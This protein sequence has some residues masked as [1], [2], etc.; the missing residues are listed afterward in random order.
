MAELTAMCEAERFAGV[1]TYIASR[2]VVFVSDRGAASIKATLDARLTV[3]GDK[4]VGVR[5]RA[6]SEMAAVL[7][8]SPFLDS[9]PNR[10][11]AIFPDAPPPAGA[12]D[13]LKYRTSERL[14]VGVRE[15]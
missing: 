3:Y 8:A 2:N 15:T 4:P 9:A 5:M 14:A 7:A 12:L 10:T 6:E 13:H 11:L 1:W